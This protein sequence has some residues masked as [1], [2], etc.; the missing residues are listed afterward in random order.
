MYTEFL[1]IEGQRI[2][3]L[4]ENSQKD[5]NKQF[6]QKKKLNSPETYGKIFKLNHKK[7][8]QLK[9]H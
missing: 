8:Y 6:T 1:I 4:I 5:V 9:Q 2:K 3:I 7:I